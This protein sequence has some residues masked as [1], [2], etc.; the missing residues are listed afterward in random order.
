V[1]GKIEKSTYNLKIDIKNKIGENA[2][3]LCKVI[4]TRISFLQMT[5][6]TVIL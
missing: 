3:R 6:Q 4:E 5:G 2:T 1:G